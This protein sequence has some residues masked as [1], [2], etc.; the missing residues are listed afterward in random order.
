MIEDRGKDIV[1]KRPAFPIGLITEGDPLDRPDGSLSIAENVDYDEQTGIVQTRNGTVNSSL[2][3]GFTMP[4]GYSII[5]GGLKVFSFNEPIGRPVVIVYLKNNLGDI[6][7][8][9]NAWYN[10]PAPNTDPIGSLN[11]YENYVSSKPIGWNDEWIELTE[12]EPVVDFAVT[13]TQGFTVDGSALTYSNVNQYRGW[14]LFNLTKYNSG[15]TDKIKNESFVCIESFD[16]ANAFTIQ[17]RTSAF[18]FTGFGWNSGDTCVLLRYPIIIHKAI[19]I[20]DTSRLRMN[21]APD[22]KDWIKKTNV[23]LEHL[24]GQP[25]GLWLG[26]LNKD[27]TDIINLSTTHKINKHKYYGWWLDYQM[28]P[29]PV[30]VDKPTVNAFYYLDPRL[31]IRVTWEIGSN[32]GSKLTSFALALKMDFRQRICGWIG[33]NSDLTIDH[34]YAISVTC[35]HGY[36]RRLT[37]SKRY[38]SDTTLPDDDVT[39]Y[40]DASDIPSYF[41]NIGG[42]RYQPIYATFDTTNTVT[43]LAL[44]VNALYPLDGNTLGIDINY[45][46]KEVIYKNS[47]LGV[48]SQGRMFQNNLEES[49][50]V[51]YSLF[52]KEDIIPLQNK[53]NIDSNDKDRITAIDILGV[54]PV[55]FKSNSYHIINI[56]GQPEVNWRLIHSK[57]TMGCPY[58]NT[59]SR[60][61]YGIVFANEQGVW[62]LS[63]NGEP[64]DLLGNNR[65]L[66]WLALPNKSSF[67]FQWQPKKKRL[68]AYV[69]DNVFW[70][71][72]LK[73]DEG[74]RGW[75]NYTFNFTPIDVITDEDNEF[76]IIT[77]DGL[78]IRV[79]G[80][81]ELT[82]GTDADGSIIQYHWRENF[83]TLGRYNPFH[84][85]ETILN[86]KPTNKDGI[87][88]NG[89]TATI[90]L[91]LLREL[92][93]I[94]QSKNVQW[95]V[96]TQTVESAI[97]KNNKADRQRALAL[98]IA[99]DLT[100][101]K[102][103]Q[104]YE[105][106]SRIKRVVT[107]TKA[108]YKEIG[109]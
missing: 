28:Y 109:N 104:F 69:G 73:P 4:S 66:E 16:G 26:F 92:D 95:N 90:E 101:H 91:K 108:G 23:S 88:P 59:V 37:N 100:W 17:A 46:P 5:P 54:N 42:Y 12:Y 75:R 52:Q 38:A 70:V 3:D 15:T 99:G 72:T 22:N 56:E 79:L 44:P 6:R 98:D 49:D 30:K 83:N 67:I 84:H 40:K 21:F 32:T 10:P 81:D 64:L 13:G 58:P 94:I 107:Q 89:N 80:D 48:F 33:F 43:N 41:N 7:I 50:E 9:V 74:K 97:M 20:A 29:I 103:I 71:C 27:I 51:A 18:D 55:I 62:L 35:Y 31:G 96:L 65:R 34:E 47:T 82:D 78:A 19:S 63:D 86:F 36:S 24:I 68:W 8:Y 77:A 45:L 85:I 53:R 2:L 102:K 60:T 61:N 11:D 76:Y 1:L 57:S 39:G 106:N 25:G 93:Q 87:L 105:I 14:F